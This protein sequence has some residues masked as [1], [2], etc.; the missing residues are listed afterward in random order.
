MSLCGFFFFAQVSMLEKTMYQLSIAVP[1]H[2][3]ST[4]HHI[5]WNIENTLINLVVMFGGGSDERLPLLHLAQPYPGR[6]SKYWVRIFRAR[7]VCFIG[8]TLTARK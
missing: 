3:R 6:S 8:L 7:P 2:L 4:F 5:Y 1:R